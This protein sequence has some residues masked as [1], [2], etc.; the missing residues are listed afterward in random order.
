MILYILIFAIIIISAI[1]SNKN[2][3]IKEK[4][5]GN[6]P[7]TGWTESEYQ[8]LFYN[9][10]PCRKKLFKG[11]GNFERINPK[12]FKPIPYKYYNIFD[13]A[14]GVS[15]SNRKERKQKDN[16]YFN[17]LGKNITAPIKK[18]GYCGACYAFATIGVIESAYYLSLNG[19]GTLKEL[20]VQQILDCTSSDSGLLCNKPSKGC[21]GGDIIDIINYYF[22]DNR[23]IAFDGD[24]LYTSYYTT[25]NE[26]PGKGGNDDSIQLTNFNFTD[27]DINCGRKIGE[28]N[29]YYGNYIILDPITSLTIDNEKYLKQAIFTYG[30]VFVSYL[31]GMFKDD[32]L[33]RNFIPFKEYPYDPDGND[34]PYKYV[35]EAGIYNGPPSFPGNRGHAMIVTGWGK[36]IYYGTGKSY[37]LVKNTWGEN[38]GLSGF[39]RLPMNENV[40]KDMTAIIIERPKC[41]SCTTT[42]S[43]INVPMYLPSS[44]YY[45][46]SIIFKAFRVNTDNKIEL[47]IKSQSSNLPNI[48]VP[49]LNVDSIEKYK[50]L[51]QSGTGILVQDNDNNYYNRNDKGV[52]KKERDGL[53]FFGKVNIFGFSN[54][55]P[56]VTNNYQNRWYLILQVIDRYR[57]VISKDQVEINWDDIYIG[58]I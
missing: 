9:Y 48:I 37:W 11:I 4:F 53:W 51:K 46:A 55:N 8:A 10:E 58:Y 43:L 40:F 57:N 36:D 29:S 7:F 2:K 18:Q 34:E 41:D 24:Y 1:F 22:S 19:F 23:K 30:P 54:M 32:T 21:G 56:P 13:W 52:F 45:V 16:F 25:E 27:A 39:V 33:K 35:N 42:I 28:L 47:L 17:Y 50:S 5:R 49:V 31:G 15:F 44:K 14:D 26:P 12:N 6:D 3:Q 20:S 38:W